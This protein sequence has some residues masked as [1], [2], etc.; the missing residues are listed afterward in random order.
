MKKDK[1]FIF[2]FFLLA[3]LVI[4]TSVLAA[5]D[6][7]ELDWPVSPTGMT[8]S[9][10]TNFSDFVRYVYEWGI[11]LGGVLTFGV[12]IWNGFKFMTSAGDPS[13][14][15]DAREGIIEAFSGLVLLLSSFLILNTINPAL[16]AMGEPVL[17]EVVNDWDDN[18]D[19]GDV[20]F[21]TE[22]CAEISY[23]PKENFK[24]DGGS[25]KI[26]KVNDCMDITAD[27]PIKSATSTGICT[28]K[29]YKGACHDYGC[30]GQKIKELT[31]YGKEERQ[32][33]DDIPDVLNDINAGVTYADAACV[34][35]E[36]Q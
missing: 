31:L 23:W 2:C 1:I 16:T 33:E 32:G 13:K 11:A 36:S 26:L 34:A 3:N 6:S 25:R 7:L 17:L 30:G 12:M 20:D 29:F 8:L 10:D 35:C 5:D 15:R 9:P 24:I 21:G 28:L 27:N 14:L 19:V 18:V 22:G 4:T